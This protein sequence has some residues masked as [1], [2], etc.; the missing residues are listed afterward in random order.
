MININLE[1]DKRG[2]I[3]FKAKVDEEHK[4]NIIIKRC[5]F[6]SRIVKSNKKFPYVIPMKFLLPILNNFNKEHI[7][8]NA[9]SLNEFLEFADEYDEKFYYI[10]KANSTYMNKWI[11]EG[12]PKIYKVIINKE[13]LSVSKNVA[14]ERLI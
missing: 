5:L 12:C 1:C 2:N 8:F 7:T 4:E 3:L 13:D 14:F 9:E 6:E 11:E 10:Y